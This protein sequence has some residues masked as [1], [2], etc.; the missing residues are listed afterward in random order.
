LLTKALEGAQSQ[1]ADTELVHLCDL[2]FKGCRSCFACKNIEGPQNG[3]CSQKDELAPL[4]KKIV[5]K[6]DAIKGKTLP[7]RKSVFYFLIPV[8]LFFF[9]FPQF[10]IYHSPLNLKTYPGIPQYAEVPP[11]IE[12]KRIIS[13]NLLLSLC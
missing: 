3:I 2:S 11:Y 7:V 8:M 9:L 6:A 4:L 12:A 10:T 1:G 13:C 5:N